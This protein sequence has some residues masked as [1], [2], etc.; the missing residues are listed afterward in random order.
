MQL[1]FKFGSRSEV[2]AIHRQVQQRGRAVRDLRVRMGRSDGDRFQAGDWPWMEERE[3]P[4]DA[5]FALLPAIK[6][7]D[8]RLFSLESRHLPALLQSA[9]KYCLQ[10]ETLVLPKK[11]KPEVQVDTAAVS[12]AMDAMSDAVKRWHLKGKCG[13][14]KQLS[15]PTRNEVDRFRTSTTFIEDVIRYCP[16]VEYLDGYSFAVDDVGEIE[17]A[18][19]WVISL[20]TWK[21]FNET[22]TNLREFHWAV[23]PFAD[24]F[25]RVFGEHVKPQLTSLSLTC[26]LSWD[27]QEYWRSTDTTGTSKVD[28]RKHGYGALSCDVGALFKGCPSLASLDVSLDQEKA[29]DE[30]YAT[31]FDASVFGDKFC[32]AVAENCPLLK[33]FYIYDCSAYE[34]DVARPI[35]AFTD[36]GLLAL[37]DLKNLTS[38]DLCP[39]LCSGVGVLQFLQRVSN[40]SDLSPGRMQIAMQLGGRLDEEDAE[41][42]PFY[43]ELLSFFE[44]LADTSEADLGA[45]TCIRKT[46]LTFINPLD[47]S[48][49]RYWS[50]SYLSGKLEPLLTRLARVHP[51]LDLK[52]GVRR[53][54]DG[55]FRRIDRIN[56][57]WRFGPQEDDTDIEDGD[58]EDCECEDSECEDCGCEDSEYECEDAEYECDGSLDNEYIESESE[59]EED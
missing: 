51:A 27:W 16:N 36:N 52:V 42:Q 45:A 25:F 23:M 1:T 28:D 49:D 35:T 33:S 9:A 26:N 32:R 48:V 22:C 47:T 31:R 30:V 43:Q 41:C 40:L 20:G 24:T 58:Y 57:G 7:L 37:A 46:A 8:L 4:W 12:R 10:V 2:L 17:C 3:I 19:M 56:M 59:S 38:V 13:G 5:L 34:T 39:T 15:V 11:K 44:C 21:A 54:N 50:I 29:E 53:Y 6:R 18:E 14:L 55:S